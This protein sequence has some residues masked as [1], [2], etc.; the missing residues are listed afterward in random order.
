MSE[1]QNSFNK[2]LGTALMAGSAMGSLFAPAEVPKS[3]QDNLIPE[4]NYM[5]SMPEYQNNLGIQSSSTTK[6]SYNPTFLGGMTKEEQLSEAYS[7][8]FENQREK[9]NKYQ[10][11]RL[12]DPKESS[13]VVDPLN[14]HKNKPLSEQKPQ[15]KTEFNNDVAKKFRGKNKTQESNF[16]N[17]PQENHSTDSNK[18]DSLKQKPELSNNNELA[19]QLKENYKS[20]NSEHHSSPKEKSD[21]YK[22]LSEEKPRIKTESNRV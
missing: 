10:E 7:Q 13:L 5:Q 9:N 20:Q 16:N 12:K 15:N 1:E 6:E 21:K 3:Y 17:H 14:P 19:N 22:S 2:K 18:R 8:N 4:S 11:S